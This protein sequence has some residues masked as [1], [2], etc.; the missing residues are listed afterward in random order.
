MKPG[1][2]LNLP[3]EFI[4]HFEQGIRNSAYAKTFLNTGTMMM[5]DVWGM[6]D[7]LFDQKNID[8]DLIDGIIEK[9]QELQFMILQA[10]IEFIKKELKEL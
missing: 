10:V 8:M 3:Q 7:H 5:E 1:D 6:L 4:D 2:K 9:E